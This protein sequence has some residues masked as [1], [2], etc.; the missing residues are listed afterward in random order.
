MIRNNRLQNF[1]EDWAFRDD[2]SEAAFESGY[3]HY[4]RKGKLPR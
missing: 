2:T 3:I 1:V 4:A